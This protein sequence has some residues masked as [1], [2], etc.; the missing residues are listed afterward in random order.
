MTGAAAFPAIDFDR[1]HREELPALLDARRQERA[2]HAT[3]GLG[4]L[5]LRLRDGG[6]FTYRRRERAL[7]I[8]PGDEAA[9]TVIELDHE[10]WQGLVHELEAP[11]GLL[12]A[13]RVRCLRGQAVDLM[14]WEP[15]LRALYNGRALYDPQRL[16]LTDRRGRSLDV[17]RTFAPSDD[18][19]DMSHFLRNAGYV[20]VRNVFRADE[21]AAFRE[22]VE[23]LRDQARPGDSFSWWGKNALGEEVLC[24]VTR[25]MARP[26]FATLPADPR[27]VA[28]RDLADE[29]LVHRSGEGDGVTVILKNPDMVEGLGDIPWHRDC[30]MGG[31]AVMCPTLIVSV[32]LTD[33]TPETGD[34]RM[35]PGSREASF[36]AHVSGS[37]TLTG[38]AFR[39]HPG[40][41]S[42][43]YS[44]TVHA[45][46]PPT[47]RGLDTYRISAIVGFSRPEARHHRGE[48]SYNE[49]LHQR[50]DGQI[51]HLV[52]VA[53]RR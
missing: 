41:V 27:I 3:Q 19:E 16:E 33:A 2:L 1:Y 6:A 31:H 26:H 36:N 42:V 4:S 24:R 5:A 38:V 35:L 45:A 34:L 29:D 21:I 39:A 8:L 11:A 49:V 43:H 15:G 25:G 17:E 37:A 13:G 22:D 32:Y 23:A 48:R 18:R 10:S 40:D 7:D 44:D 28:L 53:D 52:K 50:A 46:P 30:G 9:D 51:E 12:Y 47:A 20:F 14:S